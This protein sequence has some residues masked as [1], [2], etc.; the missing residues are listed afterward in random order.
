LA[1]KLEKNFKKMLKNYLPNIPFSMGGISTPFFLIQKSFPA[2]W[3]LPRPKAAPKRP[4]KNLSLMK[5]STKIMTK[6]ELLTTKR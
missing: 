2:N 5:F 4:N 3:H 1:E 6:K